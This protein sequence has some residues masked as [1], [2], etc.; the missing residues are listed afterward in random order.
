MSTHPFITTAP[1]D[2]AGWVAMFDFDALPVLETTVHTLAELRLGEDAVDAHLLAD[3]I[4]DDP[5]MVLKL[6]AFVARLRRQRARREGSDTETVTAALVMLGIPPFFMAFGE[7]TAVQ[8]LLAHTPGAVDGF[9]RVLERSRRAARFAMAFA[10]HRMDSDAAV[11][12][13]AALLH[14][15]AEMLLW[16]RAPSLALALLQRQAAEPSLR[17]AA[18]QTEL[19]RIELSDLARALMQAWHLPALLARITDDDAEP[20]TP[21]MRNVRLAI[22]LARHSALG[23]DNPALPDDLDEIAQLLNL[24]AD[25]TRR[26]VLQI[27]AD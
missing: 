16:V 22:R 18:A 17:S 4:S 11:I 25:A 19:L 15:F 2:L 10:V 1:P 8:A 5:L 26:L 23:F 27:D 9:L 3:A 7:P 21:Q 24:N 12:H 13:E 6:L 20:I 14:D